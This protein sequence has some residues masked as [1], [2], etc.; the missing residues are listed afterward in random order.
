MGGE[1]VLATS[2]DDEKTLDHKYPD[3]KENVESILNEGGKVLYGIDATRLNEFRSVRGKKYSR[4]IFNF[5]HAGAGIKDQDRNIRTNQELCSGFFKSALTVL[6]DD[7][8]VGYRPGLVRLGWHDAATGNVDLGR[9]GAK[10]R[11]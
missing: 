5:P 4:I 6:K 8:H 9:G 11:G 1:K 10:L 3:A 2:Y 7:G